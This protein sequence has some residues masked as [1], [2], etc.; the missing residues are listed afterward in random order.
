MSQSPVI[1][2]KANEEEPPTPRDTGRADNVVCACLTSRGFET[3]MA[4]EAAQQGN[5]TTQRAEAETE[6]TETPK[7]PP[8]NND[9]PSAE[10]REAPSRRSSGTSVDV[11]D[12]GKAL[13]QQPKAS[14]EPVREP[15]KS[16]VRLCQPTAPEGPTNLSCSLARRVESQTVSAAFHQ[17]LI[18]T[19]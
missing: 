3:N 4:Q 6:A 12:D 7:E 16:R 18:W 13:I 1:F 14:S 10:Q 9:K 2:A 8:N 15:V 19:T 5:T 17:V 11:V